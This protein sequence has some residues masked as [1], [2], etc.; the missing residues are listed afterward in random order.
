MDDLREQLKSNLDDLSELF[1]KLSDILVSQQ[2]VN[3]MKLIKSRFDEKVRERDLHLIS[4]EEADIAIAQVRNA[5]VNLI[6]RIGPEDVKTQASTPVS[7]GLGDYH[8]F[9]CDRVDQSDHFRKIFTEKKDLKTHFFYLYG[10]DLQSH[11]GIFKRIAFDLEGRLADYLSEDVEDSTGVKSLQIDLTFDASRD[12]VVYKQNFLKNFFSALKIRVNEQE[13]LI[14][15]DISWLRESSPLL[16]G[17]NESDFVCVFVGISEW[18]W[19]K[20]ITPEA[21]RWLISEFCG[22]QLPE[23]SP[24]YLFF[25]AIIYEEDDSP[26]EEEVVQALN[27]SEHVKNGRLNILPELEMVGRRDIGAW[28]NKYSFIAPGARELKEIRKKHFGSTPEHYME[29]VERTLRKLIDQ[30]N[31]KG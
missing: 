11:R 12:L 25:F 14:E 10:L 8:A 9:T 7:R 30:Y 27:E 20:E 1:G 31:G 24:T 23:D 16:Q 2:L 15:K 13:P 22:T 4:A 28:F 18:D 17:L 21:V 6:D 19:D 3:D 26:V 29:D 5:V